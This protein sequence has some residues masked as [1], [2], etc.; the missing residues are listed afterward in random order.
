MSLFPA[1]SGN[2]AATQNPVPE[3]GNYLKQSQQ[4]CAAFL[5]T[6]LVKT[7]DTSWLN[8]PSFE[9]LPDAILVPIDVDSTPSPQPTSPAGS[10]PHEEDSPRRP[11]E[12]KS[13]KHKKKKRKHHRESPVPEPIAFTGNEEYYVDKKSERGFLSVQ[14]LHRPACPK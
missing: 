2:P 10:P 13:G 4:K 9:Q 3:T 7:T 14:T 5:Q 12:S 1:Y 8:N 6:C 11:R